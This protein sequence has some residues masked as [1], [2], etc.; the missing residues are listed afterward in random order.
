MRTFDALNLNFLANDPAIR[1]FMLGEG[2]IDLTERVANVNNFAFYIRAPRNG[3]VL[4]MGFVFDRIDVETVE[5]HTL[6]SPSM[7]FASV[8]AFAE[9]VRDWIFTNTTITRMYTKIAK[10]NSGARLLAIKMGFRDWHDLGLPIQGEY[11]GAM[12]LSLDRWAAVCS[13]AQERGKVFHTELSP[14]LEE[15]VHHEDDET[16]DRFVGAALLI[17]EAGNPIKGLDLYN[18]WARMAGYLP[19]DILAV[20]PLVV[21]IGTALVGMQ[22]GRMEVLKCL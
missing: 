13:R 5:V 7:D 20:A 14:R 12:E 11:M 4:E 19:V 21:H 8:L 2:E 3:K 10:P 9:E 18:R 22:N 17:A 6:C 1:P 15:G 16:H